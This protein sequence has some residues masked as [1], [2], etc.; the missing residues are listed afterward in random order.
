MR[1]GP[2][3]GA[4]ACPEPDPPTRVVSSHNEWDPLEEVIVGR[5]DGATVPSWHVALRATMPESS[6]SFFREQGGR[7]FPPDLL[8]AAERE[9]EELVR[10]LEGEGV[11]VRRPDPVD[12]GRPFATPAW[13]SPGG[14]YGAM[15]RD[16]LL[17]VGDQLIEAP[18]AWRCRYF[19]VHGYR[20][21][22]KEYFRRGAR[23][24]AA[25]RPELG[26]ELYDGGYVE[27]PEG[28]PPRFCINEHEPVFDAADFI[29]CGRDLFVQKSNVT[30]ELGIRW[31]ERHLGDAY[32]VHVI[33]PV[34]DHPMHIDATL[35][36]LAPGKMLVNPE[37]LPQAPALFKGWEVLWAPEPVG[38]GP[39]FSMC[40]DWINMNVLSLDTERVLVEKQEEPMV[41]K[42]RDWG[43]EPVPCTLRSFNPLG[44]GFHCCT[45]DVR[46]RGE[47]ESY[48]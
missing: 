24:T 29:R 2:K 36:P 16:L 5:V 45:L 22:L 21:L 42:L 3:A 38:R 43:F 44:G 35:M 30:N 41:R 6:W 15:P 34:D 12:Y 17:V 46:R 40:S 39:S 32:R 11:T 23:W 31:L 48:F 47:L 10:I 7:P 26:D 37:R 14:L 28:A 20:S 33:E 1:A 27:A 13:E 19:E 25:P 18:M 8:A 9:L 4:Q